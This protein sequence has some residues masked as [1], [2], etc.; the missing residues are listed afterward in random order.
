MAIRS[1]EAINVVFAALFI[2]AAARSDKMTVPYFLFAYGSLHFSYAAIPLFA[3]APITELIK[4]HLEGSG[5]LAHISSLLVL[6][7]AFI[8]LISRSSGY[9]DKDKKLRDQFAVVLAA[10]VIGYL[11][12][13]RPD[14]WLQFKNTVAMLI[15]LALTILLI[16]SQNKFDWQA[17]RTMVIAIV[18]ILAGMLFIASYELYSLRSWASFG[19]S[20]GAIIYRASSLLF[21][22]NLYGMWCALL[23]LGFAFLFHQGSGTRWILLMAMTIAFAGIYLSGSRSAGF[24]L[25]I[26]FF[27]IALLMKDQDPWE[28]WTPIMSMLIVFLIIGI[29]SRWIGSAFSE[30]HANWHAIALLGERFASYPMQ[31]AGYLLNHF[32]LPSLPAPSLPVPPEVTVSI[33]G[34]FEGGMR[35]SGW[36]VLYDDTGWLGL[37]AVAWLWG[38]FWVW[39]VRAYL[40]MRDLTSVYALAVLILTIAI[41]AVMRFQAFPTGLFVALVLAPCIAYWR[42]VLADKNEIMLRRA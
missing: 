20:S 28:R 37:I 9:S 35:D 34:R 15:M 4:I 18:W 27:A 21:N 19:D 41:G 7:A 39:G 22:P 29:G 23:A 38:M 25:L 12:N 1:W 5:V 24:L 33:E 26:I 31:L 40:S 17:N 11:A 8:F 42:K 14:D 32:H 6:A 3:G 13:L 30:Q 10:I 16:P 2:F 36:L